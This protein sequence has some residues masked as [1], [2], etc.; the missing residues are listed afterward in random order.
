MAEDYRDKEQEQKRT[1][2]ELVLLD[3]SHKKR[4][5]QENKK[6]YHKRKRLEKEPESVRV[7]EEIKEGY[8]KETEGLPWWL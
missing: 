8:S 4:G 6:N 2:M 3:V 5:L 7:R 1:D